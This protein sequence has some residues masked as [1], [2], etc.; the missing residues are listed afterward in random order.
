M[1]TLDA[2]ILVPV[3]VMTG[4]NGSMQTQSPTES[5]QPQSQPRQPQPAQSLH[6]EPDTVRRDSPLLI[7]LAVAIA[8]V[9]A[10]FSG[11]S[12]TG[13]TVTDAIVTVAVVG[14]T[15]W[16]GATAP[17]WVLAGV[18]GIAAACSDLRLW[19]VLGLIGAGLGLMLGYRRLRSPFIAA[20]SAGLSVQTLVHLQV[21]PYLGGSALLAAV[22]GLVIILAGVDQRPATVRKRVRLAALTTFVLALGCTAAFAGSAFF[23]RD[24]LSVGYNHL[25]EGLRQLRAGDTALAST[26]LRAAATD[27]QGANDTIGGVWTQPARLVPFVAQHR[28]AVTGI[29]GDAAASALAAAEALDAVDVNRLRVV[30]G[31]ID[32]EA[33]AALADPMHKL[34]SAVQRM[35]RTLDETASPWLFAPFQ[36][37]LVT[38]RAKLDAAELQALAGEATGANG[39][40]M[41]GANGP[42]KYLIAFTSSGEVRGQSGLVGNYSELTIDHGRLSQSG[43]G[44]TSQLINGIRYSEPFALEMPQEFLARYGPYGAADNAGNVTDKFWSNVTMSPDMPSVGA[45]MAQMYAGGGLGQVDGVFIID[46]YGL[47]A[48]LKVTGPVVVPGIAEPFT[49]ESLQNFLLFEQYKLD[50]DVRRD[51]LEGVADATIRLLLSADL[52][53]PEKLAHQLGP[54]A[55]EGHIVGWAS[56]P[57]EQNLLVRIGMSGRLPAPE[58]TDG[59]AIVSNNASGSKIDSFLERSET[60]TAVYDPATGAV[61]AELAITLNNTAPPEGYADYVIGNLV[62]LPKGTNRTLLS[63]YSPL[64]VM[65]VQIDGKS[66][67]VTGGAEKGWG[68]STMIV[69]LGPGES[70]TVNVTLAGAIAAD[71]YQFLWRP[72]PL[73]RPDS[74]ALS[75]R[76]A[77]GDPVAAAAGEVKRLSIISVAGTTATR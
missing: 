14:L 33:I 28:N 58:H 46:T 41:L 29:V 66:V 3:A 20:V 60:Y 77:K 53:V 64:A 68:T 22:L 62:G 19:S 4:Q 74:L 30:N 43:F 49:S 54:A 63:V 23:A 72:Q 73:T 31:S 71:K 16:A 50:E 15:T 44:R 55:T 7:L 38:V 42:R 27:L 37:R 47:A 13:Q 25:L 56:R 57:E 8:S 17:W 18:G 61:R 32:V 6:A 39:P 67:E 5:Q 11:V 24:R 10:A 48:L 12:P 76:T 69:D 26:T 34:S 45:A 59:L 9:G 75:V 51:Q 35:S 21:N 40:A 2:R 36:E 65:N 70:R 1:G 52:P